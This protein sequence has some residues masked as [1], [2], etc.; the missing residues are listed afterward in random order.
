MVLMKINVKPVFVIINIARSLSPIFYNRVG[1]SG[2]Y[3][4]SVSR[5]Y[6]RTIFL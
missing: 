4:L 5:I 3:I 1:I 6:I 2:L